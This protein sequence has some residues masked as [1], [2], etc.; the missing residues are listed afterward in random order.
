M[1]K[2][3]MDFL[4]NPI[5]SC[6]RTFTLSVTSVGIFKLTVQFLKVSVQILLSLGR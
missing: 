4:V 5:H 2:K 6:L 3:H 1:E